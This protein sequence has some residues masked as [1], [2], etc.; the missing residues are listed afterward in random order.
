MSVSQEN[1]LKIEN[2]ENTENH[3]QEQVEEDEPLDEQAQ[4][5]L[6]NLKVDDS[7][8][9][10]SAGTNKKDKKGQKPGKVRSI[11]IFRKASKKVKISSNMQK[12]K[13]LRSN[14]NMRTK[15]H[16]RNLIKQMMR[17]TLLPINQTDPKSLIR[18]RNLIQKTIT[19]EKITTI[20]MKSILMVK[21]SMDKA[22]PEILI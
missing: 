20:T 8:F 2:T 17:N 18:E 11:V 1:K 19:T 15:K 21:A 10:I 22:N 9:G 16:K 13:V 4:N 6:K 3:E 12:K 14:S 5:A 7:A